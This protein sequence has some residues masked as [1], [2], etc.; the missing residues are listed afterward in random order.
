MVTMRSM[1]SDA[2]WLAA[3]EFDIRLIESEAAERAKALTDYERGHLDCDREWH[4][5]LDAE[6]APREGGLRDALEGLPRL[7]WCSGWGTLNE[8]RYHGTDRPC[9]GESCGGV[10]YIRDSD[11]RAT[12]A[13]G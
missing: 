3:A 9:E 5:R 10:S 8:K 4:D 2:E 1:W 7:W 13:R 12:L 6:R 11:L